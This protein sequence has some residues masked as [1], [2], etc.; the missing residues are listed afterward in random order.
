MII[1]LIRYFK[2]FVLVN[3]TS[4]IR[5]FALLAAMLAYGTTGFLYFELSENPDLGWTDGLWYTLVTMTT[6]G[7]GDFF[8]KTSAGRFLVGWP[9]MFFGIGLLGY[10]LSMI[11]SAMVTE[12]SKELKGMM[13]FSLRNHLVIFNFP[14][15][16]M[17]ER[18]LEE[19]RFDASFGRERQVVLV[20]EDLAELPAELQKLHIHFVKGNPTRDETL[21]R[22]SIDDA[23]H[24][25]ILCKN[26]GNAASDNLNVSITLAI[27]GRSRKVNTVVECI[28]PA[29]AELLRKAGCDRIVCTSRFGANFM[30]QELL[31][32]GMQEVIDDLLSAQKG[33]QFYFVPFQGTQATF[34]AMAAVCSGRGHLALGV[35]GADGTRINPPA[36]FT[37]KEGDRVITV[38]P[39][40]M[41]G[42][43]G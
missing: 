9:V 10:A 40:R 31:N 20:D 3:P 12:K 25:V 8:P 2:H 4:A 27:E 29:T 6:V 42:L 36:D 35:I 37:V 28:D 19:L 38:G 24:A 15:V 43:S 11:A 7:Y 14:G 30:S 26:P 39:N 41:A 21:K 34:A 22:A 32:P 17:I 33:Q 16:T 5:V 1:Q 23:A 13:T 18:V